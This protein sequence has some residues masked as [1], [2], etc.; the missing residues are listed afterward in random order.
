MPHI[1]S[2]VYQPKKSAQPNGSVDF[3]R[4][5]LE[6]ATLIADHGIDG[7]RKAGHNQTRQL[8]LL[9]R[10]WLDSVRPLGYRTGPGQFGEQI[11][12][13][14]LAIERL[15]PGARLM[16]GDEAIIEITKGRTGCSRLEAAQGQ[17]IAG[18]G[19]IGVL[20][21]VIAGGTIRVGDPVAV[22]EPV[23]AATASSQ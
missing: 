4:V 9:S 7:D 10:E 1:E 15:A 2:I 8:N 14:G 19:H 20:A 16:L 12:V 5:P 18:I 13:A 21:R 11:I 22:L 6:Q 3:V 23:S 17:S